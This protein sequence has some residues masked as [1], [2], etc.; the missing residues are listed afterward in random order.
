M[1]IGPGKHLVIQGVIP[2]IMTAIA[3]AVAVTTTP[4][5]RTVR[6]LHNLAA[7][8]LLGTVSAELFPDMIRRANEGPANK[9]G[10][11]TGFMLAAFLTVVVYEHRERIKGPTPEQKR[12]VTIFRS[13]VDA[14]VLGFITGS[15]LFERRLEGLSVPYI[16][17]AGVG[18][19]AFVGTLLS[20]GEFSTAYS[21][22]KRA[23]EGVAN[24]SELAAF[25]A[26]AM[27]IVPVMARSV[28]PLY[29]MTMGFVTMQCLSL[30]I[31]DIVSSG[32]TSDSPN[33]GLSLR[34]YGEAALFFVGEAIVMS[35]SWISH[36]TRM[37]DA[38]KKR[39]P[40]TQW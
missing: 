15:V 21:K 27:A 38:L 22:E 32:G 18:V 28:R 29:S 12:Q 14:C 33:L 17:A 3:T 13:A 19:K 10:T 34:D 26:L 37:A 2:L 8:L 9:L 16:L 24:M 23:S 11:A 40:L 35:G 5:H 25:F 31:N 30:S 1:S 6:L 39:P 36:T 7:G 4:S 20:A